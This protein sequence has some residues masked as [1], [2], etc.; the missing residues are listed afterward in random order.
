MMILIGTAVLAG[1]F[2]LYEKSVVDIAENCEI[3]NYYTNLSKMIRDARKN[4]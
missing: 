1:G 4:K 3:H 2:I